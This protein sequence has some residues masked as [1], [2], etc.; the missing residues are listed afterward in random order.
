MKVSPHPV[1]SSR[2]AQIGIAVVQRHFIPVAAAALAIFALPIRAQVPDTLK[3]SIF[4]PTAS[5]QTGTEQGHSV[6]VDGNIAVVGAPFDDIGSD[7]SGVVRVYDATTGQLL[8]LLLHPTPAHAGSRFGY[9][10][11]ISG[12][13]VVV[14]A[15]RNE[16]GGLPFTGGSAFVYDLAS[17]TPTVPVVTLNNPNHGL[18]EYFGYSV[19]I[20][21]TRV[22]AG[23]PSYRIAGG[24]HAGRAYVFDLGSATP[25]VPVATLDNPS[26]AN[27]HFSDQF[28]ISVAIFGT[29]AVVGAMWD[30]TGADQAGRA[31]V[32]DL[33]SA[34]PTVPSVT[35]NNPTP[36]AHDEFGNAVSVSGTRVV[37]GA[38]G[39]S[40]GAFRAGSAYVYDLASAT[41]NVPI[42]T[43]NNPS[44]GQQNEFGSAVAISRAR[45]V[46][47]TQ[48][49]DRG[50]V[51][52]LTSATPAV[53]ALT[54]APSNPAFIDT[55]FGNAVAISDTRVLIGDPHDNMVSQNAG[56][57]YVYDLTSATPTVATFKLSDASPQFDE[58]LGAPLAVSGTRLVVG[59]PGEDTNA[60]D[61]GSVYIYDLA[62]TT[63][64]VPALTLH[65][66]T[67]DWGDRFGYALA[68]SDTRLIVSAPYDGFFV[69]GDISNPGSVYV[70][71]LSGATP[72]VP[73]LTVTNP[74]Q[75]DETAFGTELALSGSRLVVRLVN[76]DSDYHLSL[77]VLVYDLDSATPAN[78]VVTLNDPNPGLNT[79]F[80]H[81]AIS[82]TRVV[83]GTPGAQCAYVFDLASATP[84]V[85]V[86]T[87]SDP[88][89]MSQSFGGAVAMSG[90]LVAVG[91]SALDSDD[92]VPGPVYVFD[93]DSATPTTPRV[94]LNHPLPGGDRYFG[95]SLSLSGTRLIVGSLYESTAGNYSGS[96]YVY[97]LAGAMPTVPIATLNNPTPEQFDYFG[98]SVA[99]DGPTV[100]IGALGDDA[101]GH[102]KGAAYVYAPANPDFDFD[103]L[104]DIWE[105]AHFGTTAGHSA[106]DDFDND[107][108]EDLLE[109]ALNTDPTRPEGAADLASVVE[110][111][112]L[113]ITL[114]KRA[115]VSYTVETA[116]DPAAAS[117]SAAT[118]AVLINNATTLKVRDNFPTAGA[119]QRFMRVLVMAAP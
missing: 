95:T 41:P 106:Q 33:A 4:S 3:H 83:V 1:A 90:A 2:F 96:A 82:G 55:Q 9:S 40:T 28:G 113:T 75:L 91:I 67:P 93:L 8:H 5:P 11:A 92:Q 112:F 44:G 80:G 69:E 105:C 15:Y 12:T 100:A 119:A 76:T 65:N 61:S 103:G 89:A 109:L 70:Y 88:N 81:P 108:R 35:I 10:V 22:V 14:G 60:P 45:L 20:S 115:G 19:A 34:T 47:G 114:T 42:V 27:I 78:P 52:D 64:T 53:P 87:L 51:Y 57:A 36:E 94:T 71:D 72:T 56:A 97:D 13:R 18:I 6:A 38:S 59:A 48:Y 32:Y 68:I 118:T 46:V 50:Y 102:E 25:T 21:G 23:T 17:A 43:L 117:F 107:G 58:G 79:G 99:V 85:P 98:Y 101:I 31:Y 116:G 54:L 37:V 111:G 30:E 74:S 7:D 104:L 26:P 73:V 49:G 62:S 77:P 39:D 84:D 24:F 16:P 110:G 66:P 29:T 63:P 86:L